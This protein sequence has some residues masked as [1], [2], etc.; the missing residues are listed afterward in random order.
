[1]SDCQQKKYYVMEAGLVLLCCVSAGNRLK[2]LR[3]FA[4]QWRYFPEPKI[5]TVKLVVNILHT[6]IASLASCLGPDGAVC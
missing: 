3:S 6:Q 5:R 2:L 1:M 4:E